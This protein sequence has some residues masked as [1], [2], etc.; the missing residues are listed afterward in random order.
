M[1]E[2][3]I[4]GKNSLISI[5]DFN[6]ILLDVVMT[7]VPR[8]DSDGSSEL[9]TEASK[10]AAPDKRITLLFHLHSILP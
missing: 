4:N 3:D 9:M 2:K 10:E 1:K 7:T 6:K 8:S 5:M